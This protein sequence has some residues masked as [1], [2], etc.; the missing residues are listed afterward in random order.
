MSR[1]S[2][3]VVLALVALFGCFCLVDGM[4]TPMTDLEFILEANVKEA[5]LLSVAQVPSDNTT[6]PTD[7]TTT[8][9]P[10]PT[11]TPT[12]PTDH[13]ARIAEIRD[14]F[15]QT[16][17]RLKNGTADETDLENLKTILTAVQEEWENF[18][19]RFKPLFQPLFDRLVAYINSLTSGLENQ[20]N[21]PAEQTPAEPTPT[22]TPTPTT[23]PI[24][25][26]PRRRRPTPH[27][28]RKPHRQPQHEDEPQS[29]V[30]EPAP[31]PS[32]PTPST[33][34]AERQ[35]RI[36]E[37]R[38]LFQ[39]T[40]ARMRAGV[41]DETD[42]D[43]LRTV[44]ADLQDEFASFPPRL[45]YRLKPQY[46]RLDRFI[47]SLIVGLANQLGVPADP[48]APTDPNESTET[49][50]TNLKMKQIRIPLVRRTRPRLS[51]NLPN[52]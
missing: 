49:E 22:P 47:R 20:L 19:P 3:F 37:I 44:E 18:D 40:I 45:Q 7:N 41:A 9:T 6:T 36:T 46:D 52:Q 21:V 15:Q 2:F 35:R 13:A 32:A 16:I 11:P 12:S 33:D 23:P 43:H 26:T 27:T 30:V 31:L 48:V 1:F 5:T 39:Q 25:V 50:P 17:E 24:V 14:L 51:L 10:I 34:L 4:A 29:D 42:L 38:T 28:P 8:P